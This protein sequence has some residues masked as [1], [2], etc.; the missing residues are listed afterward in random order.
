M[1]FAMKFTCVES[2]DRFIK[3]K[4]YDIVE[5]YYDAKLLNDTIFVVLDED[6]NKVGLHLSDNGYFVSLWYEDL[7]FENN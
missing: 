5:I 4:E 3:D 7:K 1:K 6:E 2:D